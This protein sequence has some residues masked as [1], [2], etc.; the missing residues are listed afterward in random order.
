M[1]GN[2]AQLCSWQ[3]LDKPGEVGGKYESTED[4][5]GSLE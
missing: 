5:A 1:A 2:T 3:P 4:P